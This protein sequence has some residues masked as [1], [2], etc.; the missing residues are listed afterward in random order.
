MDGVSANA[1]GRTDGPLERFPCSSR[2]I[3][4]VSLA[5]LVVAIVVVA[6]YGLSLARAAVLAGAV[7]LGLGVWLTMVRPAVHLYGDH[8]LVRNAL[9]DISVP[10]HLVESVEVRQVLVI[11]TEER[12]VHGLAV[13]RSAR[14]QMRAARHGRDA[15]SIGDGGR[16]LSTFLGRVPT[17]GSSSDSPRTPDDPAGKDPAPAFGGEDVRYIDYADAVVHRID[18]MADAHRRES[19]RLTSI[20]RRWRRW[21]VIVVAAVA[22]AFGVLVAAA[23]VF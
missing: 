6:A 15:G 1:F 17:S 19:K 20:D 2:V 21:E 14:K 16:G 10:W 7:L 8:L 4:L 13:G 23:I 22:V 12:M 18:N 5:A 11:R 3:G 9:T